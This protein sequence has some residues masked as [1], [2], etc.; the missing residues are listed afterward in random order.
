VERNIFLYL[1]VILICQE[2][3]EK[4]YRPLAV[5]QC[6]N[7]DSYV[8][9]MRIPCMEKKRYDVCKKNKQFL[10]IRFFLNKMF[11]FIGYIDSS[12]GNVSKHL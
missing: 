4:I 5:P 3:S 12:E 2:R 10:W 8:P 9:R 11:S 6:Y 7:S 1:K